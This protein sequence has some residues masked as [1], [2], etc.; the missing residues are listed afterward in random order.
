MEEAKILNLN[1]ILEKIIEEHLSRALVDD[2]DTFDFHMR[3]VNLG[4]VTPVGFDGYEFFN[5]PSV[6]IDDE[7]LING[8]VEFFEQN[9]N[10]VFSRLIGLEEDINP[11]I[12]KMMNE[13]LEAYQ[14]GLYQICTPALFAVTE[15]YLVDLS[16]DGDVSAIRYM[17]G[18]TDKVKLF[19]NQNFWDLEVVEG[20]PERFAL[21]CH[22][23]IKYLDKYFANV[24]FESFTGLNRH[25]FAHG[26]QTRDASKED[27]V[28][29]FFVI[30]NIISMYHDVEFIEDDE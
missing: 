11:S 30:T 16:N 3:V 1:S 8:F 12:Y 7:E 20:F 2:Y 28:M 14:L 24:N 27:V 6:D 19:Y 29:L 13:C 10:T 21:S 22:A 25:V 9:I 17:K 15:C 23:I 4:W 5:K 18:L 26:R